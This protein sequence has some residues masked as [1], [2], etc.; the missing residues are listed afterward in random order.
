MTSAP[1]GIGSIVYGW[2]LTLFHAIHP[3]TAPSTSM[4][5][6]AR[7][8]ADVP[9]LLSAALIGLMLVLPRLRMRMTGFRA[10]CFCVAVLIANWLIGLAWHRPRPFMAGA[11]QAWITH[12]ATGS[13]P[14]NH[15][16]LQWT[17]AAIFLLDR[18]TRPW[19]I[20]LAVLGLPM[21]WARVYL[22]VHY[23]GDMLG[24]FG[25]GL[26]AL[27][28]AWTMFRRRAPAVITA[29]KPTAR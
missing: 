29:P 10:A 3:V 13:F 23:P 14:S 9:L 16:T 4:L 11:G 17:V 27:L 22:G 28:V 12:A 2:D 1:S 6:L 15:L 25:M 5:Y 24:A 21:A 26:L 8:L 19:G 18:R 7:V 20:A